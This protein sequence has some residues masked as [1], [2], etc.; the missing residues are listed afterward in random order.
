M[1]KI[2][3]K[4]NSNSIQFSNLTYFFNHLNYDSLNISVNNWHCLWGVIQK[5]FLISKAVMTY[6]MPQSTLIIIVM[7][8]QLVKDPA[9][10]EPFLLP[11]TN[12]LNFDLEMTEIGEFWCQKRV[13]FL[14]EDHIFCQYEWCWEIYRAID[15]F[16]LLL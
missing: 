12:W 8:V 16:F 1:S 9:D 6:W 13:Q 14:E 5:Q 11:K 15:W 7:V 4:F 3:V 10:W 2:S